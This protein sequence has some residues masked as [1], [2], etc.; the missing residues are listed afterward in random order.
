MAI[1]EDVGLRV[2]PSGWPVSLGPDPNPGTGSNN[3]ATDDRVFI[4]GRD[5]TLKVPESYFGEWAPDQ[6]T[7]VRTYVLLPDNKFNSAGA[8]IGRHAYVSKRREWLFAQSL[9]GASYMH[10]GQLGRNLP[11]PLRWGGTEN[12]ES[13]PGPYYPHSREDVWT[14]N[15]IRHASKPSGNIS[16][17]SPV[18]SGLSSTVGLYSGMLIQGPGIPDGTTIATVSSLGVL[19][20]SNSANESS[21]G[22]T[23]WAYHNPVKRHLFW[24]TKIAKVEGIG[25]IAQCPD[26]GTGAQYVEIIGSTTSGSETIGNVRPVGDSP[27]SQIAELALIAGDGIPVGA[28]VS[29]ITTT[30]GVITSLTMSDTAT[31]TGVNIPIGIS[32]GNSKGWP[33]NESYQRLHFTV[34][35]SRPNYLI[36]QSDDGAF[37]GEYSRY[38]VW[39]FEPTAR[40]IQHRGGAKWV[41]DPNLYGQPK[42]FF[43]SGSGATAVTGTTFAS[44]EGLPVPS[45]GGMVIAHWMDVPRQ[46]FSLSRIT[47]YLGGINDEAFPPTENFYPFVSF[48]KETLMFRSLGLKE[49]VSVS[50]H[51]CYDITFYFEF[52]PGNDGK[53]AWKRLL[54]NKGY[55]QL[56]NSNSGGKYYFEARSFPTLFKP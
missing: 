8:W 27:L 47:S 36:C 13:T 17:G 29:G 20:L 39:Q 16:A 10:N 25:E 49:K 37:G 48:G 41:E 43:T 14:F 5:Y 54:N 7:Y 9:L 18:V 28:R 19:T 21:T 24:A 26:A 11:E 6:A 3:L 40:T 32:G 22:A 1:N 45:I 33:A 4:H 34:A 56:Y 30:G 42:P 12:G 23:L 53:G 55:Y 31:A 2:A 38:C 35:F 51:P 44:K 52:A 15:D 50:G 46:A